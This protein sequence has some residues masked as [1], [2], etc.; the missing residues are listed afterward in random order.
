MHIIPPD[1]E[2]EDY[3]NERAPRRFEVTLE[4]QPGPAPPSRPIEIDPQRMGDSAVLVEAAR[5]EVEAGV[6]GAGDP[7]FAVL[8][9]NENGRL[10]RATVTGDSPGPMA[11]SKRA[12]DCLLPLFSKWSFEWDVPIALGRVSVCDP[13]SGAYSQEFEAPHRLVAVGAEVSATISI[14]YQALFSIFRE[15]LCSGSAFYSFLCFYKVIKLLERIRGENDDAKPRKSGAHGPRRQWVRIPDDEPF[16]R[17]RFRKYIGQRCPY[18]LVER[19]FLPAR[20]EIAHEMLEGCEVPMILDRSE[21]ADKYGELSAAARWV[22][23]QLT[24]K[25][26]QF[27][28]DIA[29]ATPKE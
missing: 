9:K 13:A 18:R 16:Q 10:G 29:A 24:L 20:N 27:E 4:L 15:G 1:G 3:M 5:L 2:L 8:E 12:C 6:S 19:E 7:V 23:R 28:R 26:I 22:A 25:E 21:V 14:R 17:P 11:A